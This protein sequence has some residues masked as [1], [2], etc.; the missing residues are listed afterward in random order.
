MGGG[1]EYV[2]NQTVETH[3]GNFVGYTSMVIEQDILHV[4]EKDGELLGI[5]E[6]RVR[7]GWPGYVDMGMI[8]NKKYRR[9]GLGSYILKLLKAKARDQNLKPICSCEAGNEGSKKA[10]E[11]AGFI[12]RNRV[13]SFTF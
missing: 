3:Y 13:V 8:V 4:L 6:F 9:M 1:D 10:V 2:D 12:T 5:G 7:Q 11:N